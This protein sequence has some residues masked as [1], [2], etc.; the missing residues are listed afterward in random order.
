M[1]QRVGELLEPRDAYGTYQAD[2]V[3]TFSGASRPIELT[4][5]EP[6]E[7]VALPVVIGGDEKLLIGK[8]TEK[9]NDTYVVDFN[10]PLAGQEVQLILEPVHVFK[11][12]GV[13]D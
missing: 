8:L 3:M 12:C 2:M 10:H 5:V 1:G 13:L 9:H 6:G 11:G 4:I 7:N